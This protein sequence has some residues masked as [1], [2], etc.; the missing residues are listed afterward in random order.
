MDK[1][2][3]PRRIASR[4]K[5]TFRESW[6]TN[7]AMYRPRPQKAVS[8]A[9]IE[10]PASLTF[11]APQQQEQQ[12]F[13]RKGGPCPACRDSGIAVEAYR[14]KWLHAMPM[15]AAANQLPANP[16]ESCVE[17]V[18]Q[19]A[20]Q[21]LSSYLT[22]PW[23]WK[24]DPRGLD[25]ALANLASTSDC[26][27]RT[28]LVQGFQI[29]LVLFILKTGKSHYEGQRANVDTVEAL[30]KPSV[31][32]AKEATDKILSKGNRQSETSLD[33]KW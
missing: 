26:K 10:S 28:F 24:Y 29:W 32:N 25:E 11:Q 20:V 7:V 5:P 27:Q 1:R 21:L 6:D 23:P 16:D 3:A 14:V 9:A 18:V 13:H 8:V 31:E 19:N 17:R 33:S 2:K 30:H 22:S 12:P 4:M 15:V